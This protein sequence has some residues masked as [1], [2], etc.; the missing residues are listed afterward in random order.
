M[1]SYITAGLLV[2]LARGADADPS[3]TR[4]GA[5]I[6]GATATALV[7]NFLPFHEERPLRD[8]EWFAIDDRVRDNY[9]PR[10]S[11]LSDTT[12]ALSVVLPAAYTLG[13]ATDGETRKESGLLVGESVALTLAATSLTKVIVARPR[14]Y[15]Y[16]KDLRARSKVESA[17][18]DAYRSFFSGHSAIAFAAVTSAGLLAH[19]DRGLVLGSGAFLAATTANL[20]V[21]A[22]K[23]F[24]S[25]V[26]I[27]AVIGTAIGTLVPVLSGADIAAPTGLEWAAIGGGLALGVIT[28]ELLPLGNSRSDTRIGIAPLLVRDGGG[29]AVGGTL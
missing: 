5:I 20:R 2:V 22:G 3:F 12:L 15:T 27:G 19:E 7:V 21:R 13:T 16:S 1:R 29:I 23:H 28:S 4:D 6:A 25:D 18:R 8:H 9:S 24:Y 14:P 26:A 10:A 17:G 11:I